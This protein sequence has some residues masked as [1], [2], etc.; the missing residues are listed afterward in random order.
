MSPIKLFKLAIVPVIIVILFIVVD[1]SPTVYGSNITFTDNNITESVSVNSVNL[2]GWKS[3]TAMTAGNGDVFI[4]GADFAGAP[5]FGYF[6]ISTLVFTNETSLI[7][8]NTLQIQSMSYGD[9][10]ILLTGAIDGNPEGFAAVFTPSTG[11]NTAS[12]QDITS[13]VTSAFG[14][15]GSIHASGWTG[16]AFLLG[17]WSYTSSPLGFYYPMNGTFRQIITSISPF[18]TATATWDGKSFLIGGGMPGYE[19]KEPGTPPFLGCITAQGSF[20]NLNPIVPSWIGI[21][22]HAQFDE[23]QYLLAGTYSQN[24]SQFVALFGQ[25]NSFQN[26][27]N[28]FTGFSAMGITTNG[29]HFIVYGEGLNSRGEI[30]SVDPLNLSVSN[31][32]SMLPSGT[33]SVTY[34]INYNNNLIISGNTSSGSFVKLFNNTA[35]YKAKYNFSVFETGLSN[36][37]WYLNVTNKTG[38]VSKLSGTGST[39][40]VNLINGSYNYTIASSNKIYKSSIYHGYFRIDGS[41]YAVREVFSTIT[42]NVTFQEIGLPLHTAWYVNLS[43]GFRSGTITTST[44]SFS[45]T[46][47]SMKYTISGTSGYSTNNTSDNITVN[48]YNL[49]IFVKFS[50]PPSPPPS[51]TTIEIYLMI[52]AVVVIA[53]TIVFIWRR[54]FP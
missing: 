23:G 1:F 27:A 10:K 53:S 12:M 31:E 35:P 43:N 42:Y 14:S 41:S 26:I 32:D 13:N 7:P 40:S 49:S 30:L 51:I 6:N 28:L 17:G 52:G 8:A 33:I 24:E 29:N 9:Q 48:G 45:L 36:V 21:V 20:E 3:I 11:S 44:Y 50:K 25:N 54:K 39:L 46:N 47:G 4:A 22:S 38:L 16:Q 5:T 34:G 18:A 15:G 37:R 2:S 19:G